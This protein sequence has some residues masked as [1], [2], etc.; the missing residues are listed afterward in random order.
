M[1]ILLATKFHM[2][3]NVLTYLADRDEETVSNNMD[4]NVLTCLVGGT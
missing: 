1:A 2:D 4:N 3:D